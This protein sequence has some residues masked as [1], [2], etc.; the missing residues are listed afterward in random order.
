MHIYLKDAENIVYLPS[1]HDLEDFAKG[2]AKGVHLK[3]SVPD[4]SN[5]VSN[6]EKLVSEI[7]KFIGNAKHFSLSKISTIISESEKTA[8][9]IY[10]EIKYCKKVPHEAYEYFKEIEKHFTEGKYLK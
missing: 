7:K 3:H 10:K 1:I 5:C 2:F 8:Y 6:S 4:L 9:Y